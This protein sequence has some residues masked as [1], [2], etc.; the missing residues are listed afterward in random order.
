MDPDLVYKSDLV[1]KLKN[2][3]NRGT[4]VVE[5]KSNGGHTNTGKT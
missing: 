4:R 2:I 5:Q 3:Y 1:Y